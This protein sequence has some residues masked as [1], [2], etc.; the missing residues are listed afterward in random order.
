MYRQALIEDVIKEMWF[1]NE[2]DVGVKCRSLFD[3]SGRLPLQC[4]ALVIT[5]VSNLMLYSISCH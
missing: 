1:H 2:G 5:A 4:V 3:E